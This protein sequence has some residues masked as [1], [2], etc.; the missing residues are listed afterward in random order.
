MECP[1]LGPDTPWDLPALTDDPCSRSQGLSGSL[2]SHSSPFGNPMLRLEIRRLHSS[3]PSRTMCPVLTPFLLILNAHPPPP[4][5]SLTLKD[6]PP[7]R[8]QLNPHLL[9]EACPDHINAQAGAFTSKASS[10]ARVWVRGCACSEG[11]RGT[12]STLGAV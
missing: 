3:P 1:A 4:T 10:A 11:L 8:T 9:W 6:L 7:L 12:V 2:I 5:F